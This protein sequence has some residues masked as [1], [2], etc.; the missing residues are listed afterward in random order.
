MS[1]PKAPAKR[2]KFKLENHLYLARF[3]AKQL[4]MTNLADFQQ[5]KDVQDG[6]DSSGQSYMYHAIISKTN[7]QI[8]EEKLRD[9]DQNIRD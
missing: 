2:S 4:G 3:L 6:F 8:P 5:F 7:V 9:Y 1:S